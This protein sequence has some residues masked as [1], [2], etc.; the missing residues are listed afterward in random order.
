MMKMKKMNNYF[1]IVSFIKN[2]M[3]I[4]FNSMDFTVIFFRVCNLVKFF[5]VFLMLFNSSKVLAGFLEMPDTAEVPEF[6]R[7]SLLLDMDIP[8]VKDRDPNP[9]AGPRLNVKEFRVQG[10]VEYPNLD[11]TREKIIKQVESIRFDM[12]G[13]GKLLDSGYTLSEIKEVS[14]LIAEIEKE[15]EGRHV[16]S[17]EVQKLVF[18]IREQRR[19]RGITLGMIE[20]VA[21]TITR[22][23]RERGF[24]LAKAY[25]PKQ[26]VRDGVVTIT[27]LLGEL[28]EVSVQNNKR[29]S[30]NKIKRIF[31]SSLGKP[32]YN[33]SVE[34]NLY[35]VNDLPGLSVNGYFEP[36]SQVGDTKLNV[37]VNSEKFYNANFRLDNHGS[38]ESGEYRA[39][40]D[41]LIN[42]PFGIGDRL[43]L[44]VLGAYNPEKAT[45]GSLHYSLPVVTPRL[46]FDFGA[47]TNDFV[48]GLDS[49][50]EIPGAS[51]SGESFVI[52]ANFE[53]KLS[54]SRAKNHTVGVAIS[55][56]DTKTSSTVNLESNTTVKNIETFYVFDLLNEKSKVLHQGKISVVAS[57][58]LNNQRDPRGNLESSNVAE[59]PII[60]AVDYSRLSFL[61]IPLTKSQTKMIFRFVGQYSG[62][63]MTTIS[64]FSLAGPSRARGYAINEFYADDGLFAGVDFLFNGFDVDTLNISGEKFKD[65]LQ[66][67]IFVDGGYGVRKKFI[68][69]ESDDGDG[70]DDVTG[71][72][73]D[74]GVGLKINFKD[75]FRG[76]LAFAIPVSAKD[77]SLELPSANSSLDKTPGDGM[78]VYFDLQI[79]F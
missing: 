32:V 66:P 65:I 58:F 27:L 29:Y 33:D 57:R 25:I 73:I 23:Y 8:S 76:N 7:D 75:S 63:P 20:A 36:G 3:N 12:M 53:Y 2:L 72:L 74:A 31:K 35:L 69:D 47:S 68:G 10:L 16:G 44:G 14:D 38:E 18:L 30:E 5:L 55:K 59:E 78:R 60:F 42:N 43:H 26:H 17:V 46:I 67:F 61:K 34:E 54:R 37:N 28:G 15:T 24:I 49:K 21:E 13:E 52:D 70:N 9:E 62:K 6:E 45:Y 50:L 48:A 56:I 64:Q 71:Y 40:S 22:Y 19:Q 79:G 11:I 39:Y 77:S 51:I 41:L 4:V 1:L